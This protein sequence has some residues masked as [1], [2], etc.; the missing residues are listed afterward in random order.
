LL[1]CHRPPA[2]A[3]HSCIVLVRVR[4]DGP[5]G[6]VPAGTDGGDRGVVLVALHG[7][8]IRPLLVDLLTSLIVR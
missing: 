7:I 2:I 4:A 3:L 8:S 1:Q 6:R 5:A